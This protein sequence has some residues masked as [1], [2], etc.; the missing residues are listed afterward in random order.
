MKTIAILRFWYEGNSFS[1]VPARRADF[2]RREW[3]SGPAARDFYRGKGLETGAAV[4]FLEEHPD[5]DG[6]FLSCAAAY[7]G[8]PVEAGL[9]PDFM[10]RIAEGLQGRHWDGV[11]ASLHGATVAADGDGCETR[12][13]Q[14][15]RARAPSAVIAASFD[16]HANLDP[17]IAHDADIVV[18]YKTHPHVDMYETGM[19]ALTLLRRAMDGEIRPR[20]L[21]RPAGFAPTSFNMRTA[22]GPM[23]EMAALAA[24]AEAAHGF[25]DVSA[26][27]GFPYA[28][29]PHTGAGVSLCHEDGDGGA[30]AALRELASEFAR[31]APA[32]DTRLPEP[33]SVLQS[34]L[35]RRDGTR[36]A[37]LEPSDNVF[38]GGAGD[39]P[40]LLRAALDL[41]PHIP[42]VF[43]F[44][45]DPDLVERAWASGPGAGLE[46]SFGARLSP[47]FG[48]PVQA[49]GTVET[50][51]DGRFV[52][53]GPMEKGL[54]VDL[55]PTAV[56][57]VGE[58]RII[59]TSENVPVNDPGYFRLHGLDPSAFPLVYAKAKNHFRA[60]FGGCFD[61]IVET[62]TRGPAP[63]DISSLP[64]RRFQPNPPK[65]RRA[66]PGDAAAIA[67]LHVANWRDTYRG[68]LPDSYLDGD[69]EE[70]RRAAWARFF[71]HPAEGAVAWVA[72]GPGRRLDGF[73]ALE[74]GDEP[75]YG[76]LIENLHVAAAARG[77]G[78]GKRLLARAAADLTERGIASVCLWAYDDNVKALAF[79]KSIGGTV[80]A[81]GTDPFAGADAPHTRVGWHDLSVLRDL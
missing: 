41:A 52:N 66:G 22:N 49:T 74:K 62:E 43:A 34:F 60:A 16:L 23:G 24:E 2:Q 13:L 54:A 35:S 73:I 77:L 15:V 56:I 32:F 8:G 65:I 17:D 38:S 6:H 58:I 45:R 39:T 10:D 63:S 14:A 4:D 46:C 11:Y 21:I 72:V 48:A 69:I 1:P 19:K 78:I 31:R 3:L 81:H 20:S 67:E 7:P 26:F 37:I 55:G 71:S 18:G 61:A 70:E 57:R 59:V 64:Y 51:T 9:F 42:A 33:S 68:T 80:D 79:Y 47:H 53:Q 29:G 30:D 75:G 44:F 5:I 76:A 36:M 12:L 50:V 27:G 28:D 25:Y 40:D